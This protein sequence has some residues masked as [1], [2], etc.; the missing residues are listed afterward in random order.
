MTSSMKKW[1]LSLGASLALLTAG[2]VQGYTPTCVCPEDG[3]VFLSDDYFQ[4]STTNGVLSGMIGVAGTANWST[5]CFPLVSAACLTLDAAGSIQLG[6]SSGSSLLNDT[7]MPWTSGH[8]DFPNQGAGFGAFP[9]GMYLT[10]RVR[11]GD[12]T[13][14]FVWGRG[15][16]G[17]GNLTFSQAWRGES[18]S[19]CARILNYEQLETELRI[20]LRQSIAKITL[21]LKNI[22]QQTATVGMRMASDVES[23]GVGVGPNY[24]YLPG[25]RP[26]RTDEVFVGR[27]RLPNAIEFYNTRQDLV[28]SSRYIIKK[29][30]GFE[31]AS[32][33]DKIVVTNW[34]F[35]MANGTDPGNIWDYVIIPDTDLGNASMLAFFDV[36][37]TGN[38]LNTGGEP[39][40]SLGPQQEYTYTFY[41]TITTVDANIQRPLALGVETLP[42]LDVNPANPSELSTIQQGTPGVFQVTADVSNLYY[43]VNKEVDLKNVVLDISLDDRLTLVGG[44]RQQTIATLRPNQTA[45]VQ[46]RVQ[47]N[48]EIAGPAQIKVSVQAPPAPPRTV[49]RTIL[50]AATSHRTIRQGFQ[51]TSVP[52]QSNQS[53]QPTL[54]LPPDSFLAKRWN[55]DREIYET[56]DTVKPGAGFWLYLPN[57][58]AVDTTYQGVSFVPGVFSDSFAIKIFEGWNQIGNPYPYALPLG[59]VVLVDSQDPSRSLNFF[60]ARDSG[61]IRGVVYYWDEYDQEYKF[62]S[63]PATYIQPHR[64]YWIKANRDVQFIFPPVFIPGSGA[65]GISPGGASRSRSAPPTANNWRLQVVAR[66]SSNDDT[67]NFIGISPNVNEGKSSQ[68]VEEP[69]VPVFDV[70]RLSVNKNNK[71]LMQDIRQASGNRWEYEVQVSARPG[72]D[73]RLQ[74]PNLREVPKEIALRLTDLGTLKTIN[75]RNASEYR[76]ESTGTHRFKIVAERQ[77]R[78]APLIT[79]VNVGSAGRGVNSVSISYSLSADATTEVRVLGTSGRQIASLERGRAATRGA[80]TLNWSLRDNEGRSVPAGSYIVEITATSSGGERAR[81]VRPVVVTR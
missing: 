78:G 59:N 36:Q 74:W 54:N 68:D 60:E 44:Q 10:M 51:L 76:F 46:W 15:A 63:D 35:A 55:P 79:N 7:G 75:L 17:Q 45:T 30:T 42:V 23:G 49:T 38:S 73:V 66:A 32:E 41:V 67:Q 21:K 14:T 26:I 40:R 71:A 47:A 24:V 16:E 56:V 31:D 29:I 34:G 53:L 62:T 39:T 18:G 69:P 6:T 70:A 5:G 52:F 4:V 2:Y 57:D 3:A 12:E 11:R 19:Y 8:S 48:P 65:G 43:D 72:E 61:A 13:S 37:Q 28:G 33:A 77:S 81:S 1:C 58:T 80:N 20:E 27:D 22:G 25:R 50:V 64:G 9:G